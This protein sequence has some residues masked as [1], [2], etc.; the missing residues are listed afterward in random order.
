M[1]TNRKPYII[2]GI[3]LILLVLG[4]G[5]WYL[6]WSAPQS[7]KVQAFLRNLPVV[8]S[9]LPLVGG[10]KVTPTP[11]TPATAAGRGEVPLLVQVVDKEI[12]AP[13]LS[14]DGKFLLY[15]ARENGHVLTSDLDGEGERSVTNLTVPEMFDALWAPKRNRVAVRYYEQDT[16]KSFL[17]GV[18]T[19]TAPRLLPPE[20]IALD[21]SP[22]GQSLAYLERRAADTALVIADAGNQSPRVVYTTPVP[23]F[24]VRWAAANTILLVSRPSGLAPSLVLRFN[25]ATRRT[26]TLLGG[27]R[28]VIMLPAP[29][30][31]GFL[32]SQS[33]PQGEAEPIAFY[34]YKD[35]QVTSLGAVTL[36][37]KC[38]FAADSKTAYCGVPR[39]GIGSPSPD[40]WYRGA[41]VFSDAI[42]AIELTTGKTTTLSEGAA[43][44]DAI[45][46]FAT[47][48][49]KYLF[50]QDKKTGTLWRLTLKK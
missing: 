15:L 39:G 10:G 49:G 17:N 48:D 33:S 3:I 29:N 26:D 46:L 21:W 40:Q 14:T 35:G 41:E 28:G 31:G 47:P 32:F 16:V 42:V 8:G 38:T 4:G 44:V 12:F 9:R 7:P 18:A 36:V 45:N 2:V 43:G 24:T 34:S 20:T 25:I 19:G 1:E 27:S 5:A 23:D 11:E 22:D 50:F 30:A 13:A 6:L 37:E